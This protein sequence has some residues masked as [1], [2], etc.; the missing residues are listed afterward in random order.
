MT[1]EVQLINKT[2]KMKNILNLKDIKDF[3]H[4]TEEEAKNYKELISER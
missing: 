2:E 4:V 3:E 1:N